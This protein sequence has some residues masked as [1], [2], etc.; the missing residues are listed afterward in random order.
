MFS[1]FDSCKVLIAV[2]CLL[3]IQLP[4]YLTIQRWSSIPTAST[5][6]DIKIWILLSTVALDIMFIQAVFF[7]KTLT[8]VK[9]LPKIISMMATLPVFAILMYSSA[10]LNDADNY[11]EY[12]K[13]LWLQSTARNVQI[14]E[15]LYGLYLVI[16]VATCLLTPFSSF[17]QLKLFHRLYIFISYGLV[18]GIGLMPIFLKAQNVPSPHGG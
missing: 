10:V 14:F 8:T 3:S 15:K 7:N 11:S 4:A 9:T 17:F 1:F 2:L 12:Q 16:Y 18:F 5:G 6:F 13:L